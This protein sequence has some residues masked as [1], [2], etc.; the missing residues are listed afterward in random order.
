[1]ECFSLSALAARHIRLAGLSVAEFRIDY[2]FAMNENQDTTYFK[3][4]IE[5]SDQV[6]QTLLFLSNIAGCVDFY[7]NCENNQ[8]MMDASFMTDIRH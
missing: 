6:M 4:P 5:H 8:F 7:H 2:G 1:M 3:C